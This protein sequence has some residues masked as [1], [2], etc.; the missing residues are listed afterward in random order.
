VKK[1][2]ILYSCVGKS[3]RRSG[4]ALENDW[5]AVLRVE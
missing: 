5:C 3:S 2:A 4:E 1:V